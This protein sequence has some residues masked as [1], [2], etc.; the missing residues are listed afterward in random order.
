MLFLIM[1]STSLG[2]W[3][4]IDMLSLDKNS[5]E[6]ADD[7]SSKS[8]TSEDELNSEDNFIQL[9]DQDNLVGYDDT[10]NENYAEMRGDDTIIG[11]S[12]KDLIADYSGSDSIVGG[13][14][15]DF[16]FVPEL[17]LD[18]YDG[19]DT[20]NGSAGDDFLWIDD[21][22]TATGGAG[23]DSFVTYSNSYD[24]DND[25]VLITDFDRN[26]DTIEIGVFTWT[27]S[28]PIDQDRMDTKIDSDSNQ[29]L[30][31][32]DDKVVA[33]LSGVYSGIEDRIVLSPLQNTGQY[34]LNQMGLVS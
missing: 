12:E 8:N 24:H 9:G 11:G 6:S 22:D 27:P 10:L 13:A 31:Y 15:N 2:I 1:L 23:A 5:D 14:G 17:D 3:A 30:I 34:S 33:K 28:V 21:G 18:R 20:V 25:P 19:T 26:N 16:I 4:T 32:V 29:T 7:S